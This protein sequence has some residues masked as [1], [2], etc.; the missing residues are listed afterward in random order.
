MRSI[1]FMRNAGLAFTILVTSGL[2]FNAANAGPQK[3]S[4]CAKTLIAATKTARYQ[5]KEGFER[6]TKDIVNT[7]QDNEV[8]RFATLLDGLTQAFDLDKTLK[9]RG[10]YT[11][12]AVCDHGFKR[13]QDDDLMSLF[14]NKKKL[15]QVLEYHIVEG[16]YDSEALKK[17]KKFK[18]IEGHEITINESGGNLYADKVLIQTVDV[19]CT[20]GII[21]ILDGVVMPPLSQ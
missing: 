13:M 20:N 3:E 2:A 14:A 7:L 5:N 1:N 8:T 18:T 12:F 9:N 6:P 11:L 21:H 17:N 19:P 4:R 10:P 15:R 16:N